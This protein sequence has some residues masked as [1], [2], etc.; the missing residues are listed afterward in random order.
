M[1]ENVCYT[2]TTQCNRNCFYCMTRINQK[3]SKPLYKVIIEKLA[4]LNK[5]IW[6]YIS[7]G[8]PT[9]S[10]NL[11]DCL[12]YAK[13][14]HFKL[15][16]ASNGNPNFNW[17][18]LSFLQDTENIIV[19]TLHYP[20]WEFDESSLSGLNYRIQL[21]YVPRYQDFIKKEIVKYKNPLVVPM[22]HNSIVYTDK[23]FDFIN[24]ANRYH[25]K[26][27]S[28]YLQNKQN[29]ECNVNGLVITP[30]GKWSH[31]SY[32]SP[33]TLPIYLASNKEILQPLSLQCNYTTCFS[34]GCL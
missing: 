34:R 16:I 4:S 31:C 21:A 19:I 32:S 13:K 1:I 17:N 24:I 14:Y 29:K 15:G 10:K 20:F 8:E 27:D 9:L 11:I 28:V 33:Y 30:E 26:K 2:I 3:D 23:D 18:S 25:K 6:F 5:E 7:G 12:L 22:Y